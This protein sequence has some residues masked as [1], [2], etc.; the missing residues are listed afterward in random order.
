MNIYYR[1]MCM[2]VM[3]MFTSHFINA[4]IF[5][6]IFDKEELLERENLAL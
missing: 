3:N 2:S 1:Y 5:S 4:L 6:L